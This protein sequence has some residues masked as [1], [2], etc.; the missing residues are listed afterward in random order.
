MLAV[1]PFENLSGDPNED[2]FSDGL[3]EEIITQLGALSP[4]QLGVIARTTSMAY[5]RT[6]KSGQQIARELGVDYILESSIRR[7]GN[8]M[9]ISVQ[10]IRARDQVHVWAHSYDRPISSITLQEEVAKAVAEQIRIKLRPAYSGPPSLRPLDPQANEAYLRGRYFE[11]E[12]TV[13]GYRKAITYFQQAIDREPSFAEAYSGL[14]DSY[15]FLV[16]TDAMSP[17]AG[18]S[19]ALDAA[20]HAVTLGE[21]LAETQ[22]ALGSVML[23]L[24]D[25]SQ[26][27]AEFKP[28]H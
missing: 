17:Q 1:L 25:W 2:Y 5:K 18:E 11:N 26:A 6:S 10:L 14:A 22:N 3:T 9:R 4:D 23:G 8:Q 16:V 21:G 19:N 7:D 15:Y 27:E 28:G 20:R 13:V 24:L 12:F